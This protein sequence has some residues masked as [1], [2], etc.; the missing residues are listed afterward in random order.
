ML[1]A[2]SASRWSMDLP[3][4]FAAR[5]R[6]CEVDA[7]FAL[8]ASAPASG[9]RVLAGSGAIG[10][11]QTADGAVTVFFQRM[12]RQIVRGEIGGDVLG[13]PVGQ[14]IELHPLPILLDQRQCG[15]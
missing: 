6:L 11:R 15:A 5:G 10:A 7:A 1:W 13:R 4:V 8:V 12:A 9:A 2:S 3:S 14:G